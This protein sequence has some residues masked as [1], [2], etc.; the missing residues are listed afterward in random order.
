[1]HFRGLSLVLLLPFSPSLLA[2][3]TVKA[4]T[5]EPNMMMAQVPGFSVPD[6]KSKTLRQV[7]QFDI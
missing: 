1:M 6:F 3:G 4:H 2:Q 5:Q 7:K